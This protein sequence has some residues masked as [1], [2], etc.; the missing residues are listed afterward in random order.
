MKLT[1][2]SMFKLLALTGALSALGLL[3]SCTNT[4]P[5]TV[6]LGVAQPLTGALGALG[7]DMLNG[8][9]LAVDEI[10]KEGLVVNS[11]P[12]TIEIVAVDDKADAKVGV[13][14]AQQLVDQGVIA[15]IGHLNSGISIPA[16]PIYAAKNIPQLAISTKTEYTKLGLPTTFRLV[17][18]DA[19]QGKALGQYAVD[20]LQAN[21]IAILDDGTPYGK[22]LV[23]NTILALKTKNKVA[24]FVASLDDKTTSFEALIPKIKESGADTIISAL[25]DFQIIALLEQMKKAGLN[26]IKF[27]GG[28]L[29]KTDK[30]AKAGELT[31]NVTATSPVLDIKEF[32]NGKKFS[33]QYRA[34]F[35]A[36]VA[37]GAHYA[38]DATHAIARAMRMARS[39]AP[40][41]ITKA[42]REHETYGPVAGT[43]RFDKT[44]EVTYGAVGVYGINRDQW[45]LKFRS[46]DFK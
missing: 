42:L 27:L 38:Y 44:G 2:R 30:I 5:V 17:S 16:A 7:Q 41:D 14:V 35:K 13:Q 29:I 20:G 19:M 43:N 10:N 1:T 28:D 39:I 18:S 3:A 37:Y 9:K 31:R 36:D 24:V 12:V 34:A 21:K 22:G 32:P 40:A 11:R 6:K 23:E 33:E 8:V 46:S 15:V 4:T 45:E 26:D 25:N